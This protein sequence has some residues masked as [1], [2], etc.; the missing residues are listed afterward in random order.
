MTVTPTPATLTEILREADTDDLDVLV[1]YITDSGEGRITVAN[2][3]C[4]QLTNAKKAQR[5][6]A[7][8]RFI[9]E[10]EFRLFGGNTVANM[11]RDV[12]GFFGGSS[13]PAGS[14]DGVSAIS[15]DEIVRDVAKHLKVKF[16]KN[17]TTPQ[18]EDGILKT[19][20][21]TSFEKM[22][23]AE[24]ESVLSDLGIKDAKELAKRGMAA[25]A[26]GLFA[27]TL[28]SAMMFHLSRY[29]A[30]GTVAA[31]LG[32][33]LAVGAVSFVAARPIAVF[34]GPIGWAVTG[35]WALAD[36]SSP[37]YRVTVPCVVQVAYMRLKA[38]MKNAPR[39]TG[40]SAKA[41]PC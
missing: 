5:Y 17:A 15:Y 33:G 20:L 39:L 13:A 18:V 19:L 27:A 3:V 37:A 11:L 34:A 10:R 21:V 6:G 36:M 41:L 30:G 38:E 16:D 35:A 4:T 40:D 24:R 7:E 25:I 28:T 31:L 1:D 29:V 23:P 22:L 9:I 8:D 32:R 26:S 12:K 14:T 2:D